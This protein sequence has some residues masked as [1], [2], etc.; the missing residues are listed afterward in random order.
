MKNLKFKEKAE[1]KYIGWQIA[2][3]PNNVGL[4]EL[5]YDGEWVGETFDTRDEAEQ[6]IRH[7]E[8]EELLSASKLMNEYIERGEE[9]PI[10]LVKSLKAFYEKDQSTR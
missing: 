9:L 6:A 3:C 1:D 8:N 7:Y 5:I 2:R 10:K 4:W